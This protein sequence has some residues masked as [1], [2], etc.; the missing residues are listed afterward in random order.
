MSKSFLIGIVES[1]VVVIM[2]G[3]SIDSVVLFVDSG[4]V[5]LSEVVVAHLVSVFEEDV[6]TVVVF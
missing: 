6:D 3:C 5:Y 2:C 1:P 4:V